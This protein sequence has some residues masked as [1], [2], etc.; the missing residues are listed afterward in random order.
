VTRPESRGVN[1][2]ALRRTAAK[3]LQKHGSPKDA[4]ELMRHANAETTL[5]SYMKLLAPRVA[6][7]VDGLFDELIGDAANPARKLVN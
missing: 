2:Q 3:D 7:A 1:Q 6:S 4:Q 5:N